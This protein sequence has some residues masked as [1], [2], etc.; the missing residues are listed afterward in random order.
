MILTTLSVRKS[1]IYDPNMQIC[2]YKYTIYIYIYI[3]IY[4]YIY[5]YI[6]I[7]MYVYIYIYIYIYNILC[8]YCV[9]RRYIL[10]Y[11]LNKLEKT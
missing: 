4:I 2:I 9:K 1:F 5:I 8:I 10:I 6:Y 3:C 7:S 11:C